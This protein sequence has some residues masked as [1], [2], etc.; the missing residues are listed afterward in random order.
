MFKSRSKR[1]RQEIAPLVDN[2]VLKAQGLKCVFDEG[3]PEEFWALNGIDFTFEKNKIY[4]IIG[5]SGSGKSTLVTHFNGLLVSKYG[6]LSI[7]D[8]KNNN[9][10]V[11][12][13][14]T[15]KI[16]NFK[17]LR[18]IISMVF[19]FPE[20]QLFKDTIQKDIMFG[21]IALGVNKEEAAKL[22]KFYLNRM[23]LDSSYLDVSPFELSGGQKRRVAIA[24][25]LAIQSEIII[26]DEPT[27][28]LD[29]K[30]ESEMVDLILESKRENKTV[31]VITHQMEKVLEIADEI[32]LLNEGK[33]LTS[34]K[35]YEI[36]TDPEVVLKTSI[37][38]PNVIQV[39]ND[40]SLKNP[41]F[42]K[43]YDYQP[44]N[45]KQLAQAI[46]EV[47]KKHEERN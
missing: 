20:Y 8:F 19:Q 23:G 34:G 9:D 4:C 37:T 35:P 2:E 36:F 14:A 5:N 28:G 11:I 7:R 13:P 43:L 15:K 45:I 42:K 40:L 41:L 46:N 18:K 24:G 27:A 44:R 30:G 22:A 3:T 1:L 29:P 16:K 12:S 10:I 17:R 21:P 33:I 32:I 38:L 39:I 6:S 25:I 31:I 26:F 47:I